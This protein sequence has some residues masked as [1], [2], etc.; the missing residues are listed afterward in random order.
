MLLSE[1]SLEDR[2][3]MIQEDLGIESI[4]IHQHSWM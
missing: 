4:Y 1:N 2:I 3:R